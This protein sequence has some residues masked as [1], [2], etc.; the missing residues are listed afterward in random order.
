[1]GIH[2][3]F[4]EERF[5]E[6]V[7]LSEYL[8]NIKAGIFKGFSDILPSSQYR[9]PKRLADESFDSSADIRRR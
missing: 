4:K 9:P 8:M 7:D 1:M 2:T 3:I 6:L 5:K